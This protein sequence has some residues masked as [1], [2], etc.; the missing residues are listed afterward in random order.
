L[1]KKCWEEGVVF[2]PGESFYPEFEG[3]AGGRKGTNTIRLNFVS[4]GVERI[5]KGVEILA[6]VLKAELGS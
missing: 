4:E 6:R 3:E 5:E 2:V 1:L